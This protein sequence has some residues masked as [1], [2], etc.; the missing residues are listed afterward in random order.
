[1]EWI[2]KHIEKSGKKLKKQKNKES[3]TKKQFQKTL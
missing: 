3:S 1:M 2:Q